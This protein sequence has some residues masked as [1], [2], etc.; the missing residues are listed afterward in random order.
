MDERHVLSNLSAE[1]CIRKHLYLGEETVGNT[2]QSILR[3]GVEPIDSST[4]NKSGEH[5][6]TDSESVTDW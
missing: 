2:N 1:F 4:V 5:A 6:G 3:P